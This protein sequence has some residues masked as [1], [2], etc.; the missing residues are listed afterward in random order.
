MLVLPLRSRFI[1]LACQVSVMQGAGRTNFSV[2][3]R[4]RGRV[5]LTEHFAMDL[6]HLCRDVVI[7]RVGVRKAFINFRGGDCHLADLILK[8]YVACEA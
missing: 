3:L 2:F 5:P 8:R 7:M 4:A 1:K 6:R